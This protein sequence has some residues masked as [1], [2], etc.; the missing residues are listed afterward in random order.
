M[1]DSQVNQHR[2][3]K[4]L[5]IVIPSILVLLMVLPGHSYQPNMIRFVLLG[6]TFTLITL[7]S[8]K[9]KLP[10]RSQL[11]L[12]FTLVLSCTISLT[13]AMLGEHW[14]GAKFIRYFH[15]LSLI[16][17][18]WSIK[19]ISRSHKLKVAHFIYGIL[20]CATTLCIYQLTH[21]LFDIGH[22]RDFTMGDYL[23]MNRRQEAHLL[24][25]AITIASSHTLFIDKLALKKL[26]FHA[27]FLTASWL[28]L[29]I[30]AGRA[31]LGICGIIL[32]TTTALAIRRNKAKRSRIKILAA[33]ILPVFIALPIAAFTPNL[34][35]A[36]NDI[37]GRTIGAS[38]D[39]LT[40]GRVGMWKNASSL[41][42]NNP[43]WGS[44]PDSY[45]YDVDS[46]GEHA[47]SIFFQYIA[48]WGAVGTLLLFYLFATSYIKNAKAILKS[49]EQNQA[50]LCCAIALLALLGLSLVSGVFY[51]GFSSFI[52]CILFAL[53]RPSDNIS[54][55]TP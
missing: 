14:T 13:V 40:S 51:V 26:W 38:A 31:S 55:E 39:G 1:T 42:T 53:I 15:T 8:P 21:L 23:F 3:R 12:F 33:Y 11:I 41:F 10:K 34:A 17:F 29:I 45:R 35:E 20:A 28:I 22:G 25:V 47:H 2:I 49:P 37:P 18:V 48:E 24:T 6:L 44:G 16:P 32:L 4:S 9:I 52:A 5:P 7:A 46:Y 54:S 43:L 36:I 19:E 27:T 30:Y 50:Q